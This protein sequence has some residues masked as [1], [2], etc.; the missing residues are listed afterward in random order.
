MRK[1]MKLYFVISL[2]FIFASIPYMHHAAHAAEEQDTLAGQIETI[3]ANEPALKGAMA[4][5]TV[6]S[7]E[8]GDVLYDHLGDVRMRPASSLKLFTAAAAL[9]VLGED[10]SFTTEVRTDGRLKGQ[11]L[12]G[13]LYLKGKG[14]PTLLPAD[15]DQMAEKLK[16]SGIK[17]IKG[18]LVADDSWY[19]HNRYSPDLP[20]SDEY[21][22]YGAQISALTASPNED[23]DAGTVIVE[24]S[25]G[26]KEGQKPAI[27]VS[28]KTDYVA[29]E[30]EAKTVE[31]GKKKDLSIE[32]EHGT[33]TITIKGSIPVDASKT[34]EWISVWEPA[35]Y[36]L[37]LFKQALKKQGI[38]VKGKIIM[39]TA[40]DSSDILTTHHSMPL[41]KL[42][43]PFMKLS[44]NG[45]AEVLV[46]EMG[47]AEKGEGSWEKGLE[48]LNSTLPN[49]S[50]DPKTLILRDGSGVS[51]I[52]AVSSDQITK[53]LYDIQDEKWFQPYLHALPE[54]GNSD[55]LVGG[56]LRNRMKDTPA[57][58]KIRAKTGSLST[59]SSLSGY[60]ETKSGNTLV[61][62][63]LLN[64]LIDDS[65][66]KDIEDQIA[67][68][69]ANQ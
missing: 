62:S 49:F 11:K 38:T 52:N 2:L 45:H 67:V 12:N 20:W 10:F 21:T 50:V 44:N 54:A 61:F 64:G 6:R 66:G 5:I 32:R 68:I 25:P 8:T 22:Y 48:V 41:S 23:Y 69:L 60:A 56:T 1:S 19:D 28:P 9:S 14:D 47:K 13:N 53:L 65:D 31:A 58:G 29:I 59:V 24:A 42:F 57:E 39:G 36:A 27:S 40:P 16:K 33:N 30:N 51:H 46:K 3:L 17:S 15:F 18:N 37:D 55:R 34:K 4:G 26:K 7:A 63:I 43:L 35:G